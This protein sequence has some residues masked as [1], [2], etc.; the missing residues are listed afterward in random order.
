MD[1]TGHSPDSPG[2]FPGKMRLASA[3]YGLG[4][5]FERPEA[6]ATAR[7]VL[8]PLLADANSPPQAWVVAA[9]T[10]QAQVDYPAAENA[11]RRVL[12]LDPQSPDGLNNLAYLLWLKGKP[13]D[14]A[15]AGKLAEKAVAARPNDASFC[16]TLAR[17]QAKSGNTPAAIQTFRTALQK[18]PSSLEAMIGLADLLSQQPSTRDEAR[19]LLGQ[20]QRLIQSNPRLS[21]VLQQQYQTARNTVATSL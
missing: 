4:M 21:P 16:D 1:Q 12:Q 14:L 3:W 15:E 13:E 7:Q 5:R 20:I 8:E 10:A 19:T 17:I 6:F 9:L 11:Y 2:C 18:D